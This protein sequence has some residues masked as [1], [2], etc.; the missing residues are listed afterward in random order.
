MSLGDSVG[1]QQ[2]RQLT[3][4]GKPRRIGKRSKPCGL[5]SL[6]KDWS[7]A[8]SASDDIAPRVARTC[9][10]STVDCRL[11]PRKEVI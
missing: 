10:L 9:R 3:I 4:R 6:T 2:S 1:T 8:R 11:I 7:V 5:R